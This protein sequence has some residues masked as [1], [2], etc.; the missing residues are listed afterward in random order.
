MSSPDSKNVQERVQNS[1]NADHKAPHPSP[2]VVGT[3]MHNG[4]APLR[5]G[6]RR[7]VNNGATPSCAC[8]LRF[9]GDAT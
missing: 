9:G 3:T 8:V 5:P 2:S 4:N 1:D 7:R 6:S